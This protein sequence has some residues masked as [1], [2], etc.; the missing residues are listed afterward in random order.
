MKAYFR[1]ENTLEMP[2]WRYWVDDSMLYCANHRCLTWGVYDS[3]F[4]F[5]T[6]VARNA[7]FGHVVAMATGR[8]GEII[9]CQIASC[10]LTV[11]VMAPAPAI[12]PWSSV[13][14]VL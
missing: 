5:Q 6:L 8:L 12:G 11:A 2:S 1:T 14:Q 3:L 13:D 10:G 4:S 9:L 7:V